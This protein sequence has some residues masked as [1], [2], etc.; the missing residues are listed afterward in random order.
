MLNPY[1]STLRK[2]CCVPLISLKAGI[3]ETVI[4]GQAWDQSARFRTAGLPEVTIKVGLTNSLKK[5]LMWM[6]ETERG[7]AHCVLL[8]AE[9]SF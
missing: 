2:S 6:L 1:S 7:S 3:P 4:L 8:I 9:L 5:T